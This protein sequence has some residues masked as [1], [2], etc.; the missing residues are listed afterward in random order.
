M[1]RHGL[2]LQGAS[3]LIA[4]VGFVPEVGLLCRIEW[5]ILIYTPDFC[6]ARFAPRV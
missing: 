6:C 5:L 3:F 1:G 4:T 2:G